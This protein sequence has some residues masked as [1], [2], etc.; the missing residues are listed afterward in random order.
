MRLVDA[1]EKVLY[2]VS[3]TPFTA[4]VLVVFLSVWLGFGGLFVWVAFDPLFLHPA[5][6]VPIDS[7]LVGLLGLAVFVPVALN[8][9][10]SYSLNQLVVTDRRIY[11]RRGR[12][13]RTH[14]FAPADVRSFQRVTSSSSRGRSN[15]AAIFYLLCGRT[16]RSGALYPR[17]ASLEA[18]L[19]LLR[20]RFE[21]RGFTRAELQALKRDNPGAAV[22]AVRS[23]V[24]VPILQIIP[25]ALAAVLALRWLGV[26]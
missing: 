19:A 11:V 13:G 25:F 9:L 5:G 8:L 3:K 17:L 16:V 20:G 4:I 18:L 22:P 26:L 7:F 10:L 21:G 1:E 15:E 24:L 2:K 6:D 23:N 14:V 12:S